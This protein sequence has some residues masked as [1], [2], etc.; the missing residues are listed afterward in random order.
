MGKYESKDILVL[1]GLE[2]VRL[3][4]GMYIGTTGV[5]GLHH[6]LWEIVDNSIDEITNG[7]GNTIDITLEKDGSI[8]VEDNGRGIPVD[9]HPTQ[10]KSGVEVVFTQLHAGG[11]FNTETYGYSG[12]LHGVGASVTNA[13]SEWVK[14]TVNKNNK[15]YYVEFSSFV[16]ENGKMKCGIAK[17]PLVEIG[18]ST[19]SGTKVQFLPDKR[20]F[21]EVKFDFD[22]IAKRIKELA[23]LNKGIIV[24]LIDK[25]Q[26]KQDTF[27]FEGGLKDFTLYLN[28][29]KSKLY[30]NPIFLFGESD[31][32]K[33]ELS[34]QHTDTY[35]ENLF[36]YVN[37]IPT[38]EGGTHEVGFKSGLTK[39]M[40]DYARKNGLLKEKENNLIGDD[41]REGITAV[42][43]IKMNNIQ[44]EGQTKTKLGNPE[45]KIVVDK[46]VNQELNKFF[47]GIENSKIAEIVINK[48]K[49]AAKVREAARKAKELTRVKNSIDSYN[50]VGKLSSCTSRNPALSELF[51]VEGDSAG[52][53]AKQGRDRKFQAIL[54]LK[55]KPLN[56][57]KKRLDQVLANEEIRT[58][59]S[60]LETSI[61]ADFNIE[62]LRYQKV[63][64]LSD[65]DQDGAHIRAILLTFFFR[66]M[67]EL[68]TNGNVF[69]GLPPLY[70][71]YK[72]DKTIYVYSDKELP[73]A[74]N[75]IGK[76]YQIQRYKGLGEMNPEQLWETTMDPEKRTL[77]CVTLEDVA[78]A[79]RLVVTL[80]G[81][82]I[83]ARKEYINKYANFNKEDNFI[84]QIKN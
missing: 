59:I 20:V 55:G 62:N 27:C 16:G 7:Y 6:I 65:A 56:A 79:E 80:M 34:I 39:F 47:S 5:K 18:K 81:D 57:E 4:P 29:G 15:K 60:S 75:Q 42:L 33:M 68:I 78:E 53:S 13:L 64:I 72:K 46:L 8:T 44:F 51:I 25:V 37:N 84:K 1:E 69:I 82:D 24:N 54:P 71:V 21:G 10:K 19:K 77:V 3:R 61:G 22:T 63:I 76:G 70:K 23:F 38:T 67:K 58:I 12:G 28:E 26:G 50:L 40:N 66:Y 31:K 43:S 52:G 35:T 11:K 9:I 30:P 41:F 14:V 36:S 83:I 74:L 48:A 45:V 17:S 2:A 73:D 32:I 49:G